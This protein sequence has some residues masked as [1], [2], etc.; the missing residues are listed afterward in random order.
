MDN[1]DFRFEIT[2]YHNQNKRECVMEDFSCYDDDIVNP[3]PGYL[4]K[5]V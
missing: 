2:L 5:I 3:R 1:F 4:V